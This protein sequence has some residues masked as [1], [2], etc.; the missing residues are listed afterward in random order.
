MAEG[1]GKIRVRSWRRGGKAELQP[2]GDAVNLPQR[3][4]QNFAQHAA[5]HQG[6]TAVVAAKNR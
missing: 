4:S 2:G 6:A 3:L 5:R 1:K